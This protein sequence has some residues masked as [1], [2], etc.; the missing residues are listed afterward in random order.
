MSVPNWIMNYS[1]DDTLVHDAYCPMSSILYYEKKNSVCSCSPVKRSELVRKITEQTKSAQN[2]T[3]RHIFLTISLDKNIKIANLKE[4]IP[5]Y[6]LDPISSQWCFEF[7][8]KELQFHPHI[9][10]LIKTKKK[11]DKK[12][13]ISKIAKK[14]KIKEN[15]I[16]YQF[17]N[18]KLLFQ[19]R[20]NYIKG[21][22]TSLKNNQLIK[23]AEFRYNHDIQ[24]FY[25][26]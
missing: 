6:N 13:I 19:K 2:R 9:H 3:F 18:S 23:D 12:R 1:I 15:F 17:S 14:L 25:K 10:L 20:E 21:N 26:M 11:L 16:D 7:Y 5:D 22:K 24:D 4:F 8:G